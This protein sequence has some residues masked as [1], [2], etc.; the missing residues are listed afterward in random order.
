MRCLFVFF[1]VKCRYLTGNERRALV[2]HGAEGSGK[3]SLLARAG[4]QCHGWLQAEHGRRPGET[5]VL[6]RFVGLTPQA[7]SAATLMRSVVRQ[8]SLLA[9]GRLPHVVHVTSLNF[10]K[11][12]L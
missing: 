10:F 12:F 8:A 2:V 11:Y 6:L 4:Q 5:G 7:T 1:W 9:A 3:T